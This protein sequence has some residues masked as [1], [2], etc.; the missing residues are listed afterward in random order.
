LGNVVRQTRN[1]QPR[2]SCHARRTTS[3]LTSCQ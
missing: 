1:N 2:Q 3:F